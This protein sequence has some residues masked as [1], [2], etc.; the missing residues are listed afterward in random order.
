MK[1]RIEKSFDRDAD[2]VKDKKVLK[3]LQ[4]LISTIGHAAT[5]RKIPHTKAA[6]Y[7][8]VGGYNIWYSGAGF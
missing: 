5:I 3:K 2:K 6:S 1:F 7:I 8:C 4:K